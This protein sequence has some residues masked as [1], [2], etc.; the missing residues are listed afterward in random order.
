MPGGTQLA[1]DRVMHSR[2]R[3]INQCESVGLNDRQS[4]KGNQSEAINE[5]KPE[6]QGQQDIMHARKGPECAFAFLAFFSG[7]LVIFFAISVVL[8]PY[9]L[10]LLF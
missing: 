10:S 1:M 8:C 3:V 2:K 7:F 5:W 9:Y 6:W 4:I